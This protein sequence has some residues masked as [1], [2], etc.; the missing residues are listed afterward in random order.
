M[1]LC[2][3]FDE[4]LCADSVEFVPC[5]RYAHIVAVGT[6]ELLKEERPPRKIGQI[7]LFDTTN[8]EEPILLQTVE[9][10]AILDMKWYVLFVFG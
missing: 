3:K 9:T 7:L 6:Y 4:L 8:V 5:I 1:T 10:D 2:F